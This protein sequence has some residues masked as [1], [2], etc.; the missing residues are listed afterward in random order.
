MANENPGVQ[1]LTLHL[2]DGTR[3]LK[4][5][6]PAFFSP[7]DMLVHFMKEAAWNVY[8]KENRLTMDIPA[9]IREI[10]YRAVTRTI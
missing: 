9:G 2:P 4:L 7:D 8:A 5:Y 6:D 10:L 1:E 3:T